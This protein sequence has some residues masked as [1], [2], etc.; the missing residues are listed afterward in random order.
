MI[1]IFLDSIFLHQKD[2][3][4][5]RYPFMKKLVSCLFICFTVGAHAQLNVQIKLG[6]RNACT[7]STLIFL[8]SVVSGTPTSYEWISSVATFSSTS[9]SITQASFSASGQVILKSFDATSTFY[10]TIY[11]TLNAPPVVSLGNDL[12]VCCDYGQIVLDSI[13]VTP[14]G[15]PHTNGYW[16]TSPNLSLIG[17]GNTFNSAEACG[18]IAAP[19]SSIQTGL[20]YTYQDPTTQCVNR[21]S[22]KIL[23]RSLP[24]TILQNRAYC[25]DIGSIQLDNDVVVS[26]ANTA[27]GIPSWRCLDSNSNV[28]YFFAD[29]L[30]NRGSQFA[31]DW[32]LNVD[33]SNYT[34]QNTDKDT[35]IL[36]FTYTNEYGCTSK[37]T[38]NM[39]I[40]RVPKIT[41]GTNRELCWDEGEISL[42][43]LT[44]VNLTDGAWTIYDSTGFRNPVT[45]GGL[46]GDTINTLNSVPLAST[47]ANPKRYLIHYD[48]VATGCPASNDTTLTINP[49]PTVNLTQPSPDRYCETVANM[50]LNANP[51]GGT[52]SSNDPSA[53]VGGNNFSP[54]NASRFYPDDI[55]LFYDYTSP[56]TG[57][58]ATDFLRIFI[59]A[60]PMIQAPKDTSFCYVSTG[61]P[62]TMTIPVSASNSDQLIWIDFSSR[63]TLGT[64]ASGSAT[65]T[66]NGVQDTFRIILNASG[67]GA[68]ADV[69]GEFYVF[70]YQDS[71][72]FAAVKSLEKEDLIIYPNPS[73][74]T[75]TIKNANLYNITV[76]DVLGKRVNA[77]VTTIG[78]LTIAAKGV[79]MLQLQEKSSGIVYSKKVIVE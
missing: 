7:N 62:R 2:L 36:E 49:L 8:D 47:N 57:C 40:W 17:N 67:R 52:W 65:F 29:M 68:C 1:L 72:C 6:D 26:P 56:I 55:S 37:D 5:K 13:I 10:D 32:W 76:F 58:S 20:V 16:S 42:N 12:A 35:I 50:P 44:S 39:E 34:I 22:M 77:Q 46:T 33:E 30:E 27:L 60:T 70:G 9:A 43:T 38:A 73:S 15:A 53:L 41:F 69:D 3:S 31:P 61:I 45:L 54:G 78:S 11:V 66:P 18:L 14:T 21:D 51:A 28:N 19:A 71:S 75:F 63:V 48:H 79:Y 25:Q 74:G 59:D 64:T 23:V 24:R 4:T